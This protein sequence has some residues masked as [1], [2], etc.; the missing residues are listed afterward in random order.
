M[1]ATGG[2]VSI[3]LPTLTTTDDGFA[4]AVVKTDSSANTVT[5]V[6]TISG[7]TNWILAKPYQPT[8]FRWTGTVW[9]G[10]L[11]LRTVG[12]VPD[13]TA[14]IV[15]TLL[16]PPLWTTAGR[17]GSPTSGLFGLNTDTSALEAYLNG[18]WKS[19][20][21]P[22]ARGYISGCIGSNGSDATNDIN[23]TAGSCRDST[24]AFNGTVAANTSG[25]QLDANWSASPTTNSGMRNSAA[26][27]ANGTYHIYAAWKA[28]G[29]QTIYAY[30]GVA[31]T[32]PDSAAA[33]TT[34]LTA[35]QAESGGTGFVY[36]RRLFSILRE[37]ASIVAFYQ[38]GDIFLRKVPAFDINNVTV[39]VSQ[40]LVALSV[41]LGIVVEARLTATCTSNA[42]GPVFLH[43]P[44]ITDPTIIASGPGQ[45]GWSSNSG[46][47]T[48]G[49]VEAHV[50]TNTSAQIG[51]KTNTG[52][53]NLNAR[54][55]GWRDL[56][57]KDS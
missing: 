9:I 51:H 52:T 37:S 6:G 15:D 43:S 14:L 3:T 21:P 4:V 41:P 54:T 5:V 53:T 48:T 10:E 20:Q 38:W 13:L 17:P 34:M 47:I 23:I 45:Y 32:D 35:L 11:N 55:H 24:D 57:G 12:G 27:I 29:T 40:T 50:L 2:A 16:T 46:S 26:G 18:G 31:G 39:G 49:S 22:L 44:N 8:S 1:D 25:K 42:T 28:D 30:A 19:F 36:A 56:R 33:I 7:D